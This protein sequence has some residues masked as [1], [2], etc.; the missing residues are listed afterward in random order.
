MEL[1]TASVI[2]TLLFQYFDWS[3]SI[4]SVILS[5]FF[6]GYVLLQIPAGELARKFG[7]KLLI[8]TSIGVN[9]LVSLMIPVAAPL[10]R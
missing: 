2:L 10:V 9:S 5:S 1:S 8:L 4:Q 7:G 6:W 3:H